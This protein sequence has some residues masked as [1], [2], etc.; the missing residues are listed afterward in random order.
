MLEVDD[1]GQQEEDTHCYWVSTAQPN[2]RRQSPL[3]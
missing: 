2:D 1:D 3:R